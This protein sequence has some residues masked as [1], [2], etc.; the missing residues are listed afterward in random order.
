MSA[1]IFD[2]TET[3][4]RERD[5]YDIYR[6]GMDSFDNM[7]ILYKRYDDENP[8]YWDKKNTPGQLWIRRKDHPIAFPAILPNE[9]SGLQAI[10]RSVDMNAYLMLSVQDADKYCFDF[11]FSQNKE[12]MA[13]MARN[14]SLSGQVFDR[15]EYC[16]VVMS[17]IDYSFDSV[18]QKRE[19]LKFTTD[20]DRF[21]DIIA[22]LDIPTEGSIRELSSGTF[23]SLLGTYPN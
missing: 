12:I 4:R 10:D 3:K 17:K 13:I 14:P 1:K 6:Y 20:G 8:S 9:L 23:W 16:D 22:P 18:V 7:Y 15:Y 2:I 19:L 5:V 11:E 21:D